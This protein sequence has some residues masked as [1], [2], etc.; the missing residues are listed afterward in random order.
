MDKKRVGNEIEPNLLPVDGA[1]IAPSLSKEIVTSARIEG[2]I[3]IAN[4]ILEVNGVNSTINGVPA[5]VSE[6]SYPV[7]M[8]GSDNNGE[9]EVYF[10]R[11]AKHLPINSQNKDQKPLPKLIFDETPDLPVITPNPN[12]ILF[13]ESVYGFGLQV[14][15]SDLNPDVNNPAH[16]KLIMGVLTKIAR[17]VQAAAEAKRVEETAKQERLTQERE[18]QKARTQHERKTRNLHCWQ[19]VKKIGTSVLKYTGMTVMA[20]AIVGGPIYVA[21]TI[22]LPRHRDYD[23]RGYAL[24][25]GTELTLGAGSEGNPEFS[26]QLY[27]DTKL[28]THK[29]PT[30]LTEEDDG[31][32]GSSQDMNLDV[33]DTLRNI[34]IFSSK[35]GKNCSTATLD[36]APLDTRLV[37]WTDFTAPDGTSRADELSVL[38]ETDKV[39]VCWNGEERSINDDPRVVVTL[40]PASESQPR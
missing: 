10:A 25:G 35:P 14:D 12:A 28:A 34:I 18:A 19:R 6:F 29:M 17:G 9:G 13:T 39:K 37:A 20:G 23:E 15:I 16:A 1:L 33:T 7:T 26:K 38:Y 11:A 8:V 21:S 36:K 30:L 3:E 32:V 2:M 22:D 31:F 5:L 24:A 40:R 4:S 27:E